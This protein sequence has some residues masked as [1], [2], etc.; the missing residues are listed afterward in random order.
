MV[1]PILMHGMVFFFILVLGNVTSLDTYTMGE[2][3]HSIRK[4]RLQAK[5]TGPRTMLG[6]NSAF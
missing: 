1:T 4:A 2:G 6:Q 3:D 5:L